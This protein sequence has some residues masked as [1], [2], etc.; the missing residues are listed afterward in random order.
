MLTTCREVW[1][2]LR[3]HRHQGVQQ[4]QLPPCT[5]SNITRPIWHPRATCVHHD[6]HELQQGRT[7]VLPRF[8][9]PGR[10]RPWQLTMGDR[11]DSHG[12]QAECFSSPS[13]CAHRGAG[14]E[15]RRF[16]PR[17]FAPIPLCGM[18]A[19]DVANEMGALLFRA[20][21]SRRSSVFLSSLE[22][23]RCLIRDSGGVMSPIVAEAPTF[24]SRSAMHSR[25]TPDWRWAAGAQ[26]IAHG[27]IMR[28]L[29]K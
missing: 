18:S 5:L 21:S 2:A 26:E 29:R 14:M 11:V 20:V 16:L 8:T 27:Q 15:V 7:L 23:R 25:R 19:Q 4:R 6:L 13:S 9:R 28:M 17:L 22:I 1:G 12:A 24:S 10:I 3:H